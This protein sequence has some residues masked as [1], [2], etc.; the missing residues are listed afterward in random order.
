MCKM[1]LKAKQCGEPPTCYNDEVRDSQSPGIHEVQRAL[2]GPHS[3]D[4]NRN[5]ADIVMLV[6]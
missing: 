3:T 4:G 6:T 1:F 5:V 2:D